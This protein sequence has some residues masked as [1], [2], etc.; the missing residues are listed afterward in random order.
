MCI[1]FFYGNKVILAYHRL[2][3]FPFN[4]KQEI[5]LTLPV[6]L[7]THQ[8]YER[9]SLSFYIY[10]YLDGEIVWNKFLPTVNPTD[11]LDKFYIFEQ[12]STA[13]F[14]LPPQCLLIAPFNSIHKSGDEETNTVIYSFNPLNGDGLSA[15]AAVEEYQILHVAMLPYE[16]VYYLFGV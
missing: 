3:F 12:R 5:S 1:D 4:T 8:T 2:I 15:P 10:L 14:P 11:H 16:G 13:H 6:Q 7:F 9:L